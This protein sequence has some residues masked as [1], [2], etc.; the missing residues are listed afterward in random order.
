MK[1]TL[2]YFAI[3]LLA[4]SCEG[5]L[6]KKAEQSMNTEVL[7]DKKKYTLI[8]WQDSI[9]N[10]GTIKEGEKALVRFRFKNTG[11]YP[12]YLVNVHA[13]CGCTVVSYSQ[14][15]IPPDR[16]G[17]VTGEFDSNRS[18]PGEVRKTIVVT[19]NTRNNRQH[20]LIFTG[21]IRGAGEDVSNTY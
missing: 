4:V 10:F 11:N 9:V 2:I 17:E 16:D 21:A 15:S 18:Y 12:L 20:T 8:Q 19:T 6:R 14:G 7:R 13:G 1:T 3:A 5:N